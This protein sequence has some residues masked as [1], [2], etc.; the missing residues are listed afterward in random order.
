MKLKC[1]LPVFA[2]ILT[3]LMGLPAFAAPGDMEI[4]TA[5]WER[6][7][8][9][10]I[11]SDYVLGQDALSPEKM[12]VN[13][14]C[15]ERAFREIKERRELSG[16]ILE[17]A[18]TTETNAVG[19]SVYALMLKDAADLGINPATDRENI[20]ISRALTKSCDIELAAHGISHAGKGRQDE[21]LPSTASCVFISPG[22]RY[23]S[24]KE[25]QGGRYN[26]KGKDAG[27][28]NLNRYSLDRPI[29]DYFSLFLYIWEDNP[30]FHAV[31]KYCISSVYRGFSFLF[32]LPYSG[33]TSSH[34]NS[35]LTTIKTLKGKTDPPMYAYH[36]GN[37]IYIIT[38]RHEG[39]RRKD[40]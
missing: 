2:L 40:F 22:N 37:L 33:G 32:P 39:H 9:A 1:K 7:A 15:S 8:G 4:A 36:R 10:E 24:A 35:T 11:W 34:T 23:P 19:I 29:V 20:L 16:K 30:G 31:L 28:V 13:A 5:A 3:A 14:L 21:V 27:K 25:S 26:L 12:P 38:Q 17:S 18:V 6:E